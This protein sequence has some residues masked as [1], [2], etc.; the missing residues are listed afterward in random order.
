MFVR[1]LALCWQRDAHITRPVSTLHA[2][3]YEMFWAW[4]FDVSTD[5]G[6]LLTDA[7]NAR[8]IPVISICLNDTRAARTHTA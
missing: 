1:V 2:Y 5:V 8:N 6:R 7:S 3:L 4:N